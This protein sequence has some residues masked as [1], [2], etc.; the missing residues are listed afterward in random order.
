MTT[1]GLHEGILVPFTNGRNR[2]PAVEV[3]AHIL[4]NL[5]D[6]SNIRPIGQWIRW[7]FAIVLA[8]FCFFMFIRFASLSAMFIGFLGLLTISLVTFFAF[9]GLNRWLSPAALYF[10]V[11]ISFLLAYI[12]NLQK[13]KKLLLQAKENWEESFNTI[14]DA[15]CI[16]DSKLQHYS[17]Q[18]S[19]GANL[20]AHRC[21]N[22]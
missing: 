14:N 18:Q 19:S 2:M 5:L 16:H 12:F 8:V 6:K 10:S 11:G 17:G 9:A 7:I 3:H 15:I 13:M 22:F 21:C 4:N 20:S 1:A